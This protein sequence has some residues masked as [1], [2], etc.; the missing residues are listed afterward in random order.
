MTPFPHHHLPP[1]VITVIGV[2]PSSYL[3]PWEP[4]HTFTWQRQI[5]IEVTEDGTWNVDSHYGF[6]LGIFL[7]CWFRCCQH[8]PKVGKSLLFRISEKHYI[9]SQSYFIMS[10]DE[11][12]KV[13]VPSSPKLSPVEVSLLLVTR[14]SL[15]RT[16]G[17]Q[18]FC[19]LF[20]L[21]CKAKFDTL[22][23]QNTH[24]F[25]WKTHTHIMWEY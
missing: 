1:Q 19:F 18:F 5:Y 11:I 21:C 24:N 13:V 22:C 25:S 20:L 7:S 3:I 23:N 12:D 14:V 16:A 15:Q 9:L 10:L 8:K 2:F 17:L 4:L 6:R